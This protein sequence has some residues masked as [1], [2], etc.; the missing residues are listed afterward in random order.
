VR[1]D[2]YGSRFL[3]TMRSDGTDQKFILEGDDLAHPSW[4]PNG[5]T[6]AL[7]EEA[8]IVTVRTDGTGVR[9]VSAA[10]DN[11]HPAWSPDGRWIAFDSD[12]IFV[13]DQ[14]DIFIAPAAGGPARRLTRDGGAM[15]EWSPDGK[16]IV[17]ADDASLWIAPASGGPAKRVALSAPAEDPSWRRSAP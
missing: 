6:I 12:R 7:S 10:G 4:S 11:S 15:P 8:D 5:R 2:E 9:L 3:Y 16:E 17:F 13:G 1:A 14:T